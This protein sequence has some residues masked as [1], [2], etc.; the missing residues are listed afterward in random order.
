MGAE[1]QLPS[2]R[3]ILATQE[4]LEQPKP[5]SVPMGCVQLPPWTLQTLHNSCGVLTLAY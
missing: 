4:I 2:I 5:C 3:I 1:T